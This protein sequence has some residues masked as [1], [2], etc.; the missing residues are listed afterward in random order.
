MEYNNFLKENGKVLRSFQLYSLLKMSKRPYLV[1]KI[2]LVRSRNFWHLLVHVQC[3]IEGANPNTLS[4]VNGEP[5][6]QYNMKAR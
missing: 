2:F 3:I 4:H 1:E 6:G 5:L